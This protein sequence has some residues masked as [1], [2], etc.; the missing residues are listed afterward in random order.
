M[1]GAR[2]EKTWQVTEAGVQRSLTGNGT[3]SVERATPQGAG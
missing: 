1:D 2:V 3:I